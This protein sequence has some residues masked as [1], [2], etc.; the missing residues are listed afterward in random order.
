MSLVPSWTEAVFALGAGER[1]VGATD[2][3]VHPAAALRQVARVGGTK[4]PAVDR[5][6]ALEPDWVIANREE[7][8]RRDVESLE[9]RGIPVWVT[10]PRSV[11]EALADVRS[12]GHALQ[13]ETAAEHLVAEVGEALLRAR[14]RAGASEVRCLALIWKDPFMAVGR[15]TFASDL[16][17]CCGGVNAIGDDAERRYPRLDL[18]G[19]C[20]LDPE[21]LLLPTEPYAFSA[22]ERNELLGLDLAAARSG[23]IHVVEGELLTWYGPRM[24][25]A[26][27]VFSQLLHG[28]A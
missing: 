11:A 28:A 6:V 22:R 12:L 16:L 10:Y 18:E 17:R 23:R 19:L 1:I 21:V 14:E 24:A 13:T 26:I 3:C 5:I 9:A 8:R 15:D 7:N 2:Y 25:R 20:R 27:D 4:N